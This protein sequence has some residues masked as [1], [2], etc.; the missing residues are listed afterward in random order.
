M[1]YSVMSHAA[2]LK[3]SHVE[4][5]GLVLGAGGVVGCCGVVV[6]AG[7]VVG[8]CGVVVGCVEV[9][10]DCVVVNGT[11]VGKVGKVVSCSP[12]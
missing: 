11:G 2:V 4:A 6:G 3:A 8:C 5:V 1:L 10:V 7:G 12:P 9:V